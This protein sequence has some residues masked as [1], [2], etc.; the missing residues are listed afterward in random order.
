MTPPRPNPL[1]LNP[2][3]LKTLT[4]MQALARETNF[5][6]PAGEDGSVRIHSL[7]QPHGNH[8]HLGRALVAL[9]DLSGLGNPSVLNALARKGLLK[10]GADGAYT[11]TGAGLEYDTG[12]ADQILHGG[13]H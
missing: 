13:D 7:P 1:R 12:I 8:I 5:A 11:L 6:E 4:V 10:G 9:R 2:L 3:Q